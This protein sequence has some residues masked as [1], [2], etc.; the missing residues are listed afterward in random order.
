MNITQLKDKIKEI[1]DTASTRI[2]CYRRLIKIY[3]KIPYY[4]R[5]LICMA[6]PEYNSHTGKTLI[7][8]VKIGKIHNEEIIGILE[9]LVAH[10]GRFAY[11][12][13]PEV[14]TEEIND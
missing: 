13:T 3:D 7:H 2:S 14:N 5:E 1:K 6:Y 11:L 4:Y 12:N 8:H 10:R 9:D